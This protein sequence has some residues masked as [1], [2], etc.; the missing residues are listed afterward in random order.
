MSSNHTQKMKFELEKYT[1]YTWKNWMI[2]HWILNPGLAFNELVLGQRVPKISL[3]EKNSNK[4]RL[5][6]MIVPCPHCETLHDGR[7]WSTENGMAFKNWFGL[8]CSN[9]GNIIPCLINVTSLLLLTLTFPIWGWLKNSL[10]AKWL[11]NQPKR[12]E[13]ISVETIPNSFDSQNWIQTGLTWGAIMF[14]LVSL[15]IPYFSGQEITAKTISIGLIIWFFGGLGFAYSLKLFLNK[16][17][18]KKE[19]LS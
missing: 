16:T 15:L 12:Y 4:P 10:K 17:G 2:L 6:R 9:C 1:I 7:I 19:K 5:E 18:T 11:E 13:K 8:Y 3:I 14:L